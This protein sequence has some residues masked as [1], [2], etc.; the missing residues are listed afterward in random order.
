M[1]PAAPEIERVA[2]QL[3][4]YMLGAPYP[5]I[6]V[7]LGRRRQSVTRWCDARY[8]AA[9]ASCKMTPKARLRRKM[10]LSA[11]YDAAQSGEDLQAVYQRWGC[12]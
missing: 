7:L 4:R 5:R 2:A 3:M 10:R 12:A 1:R 6:A 8:A 9:Q 11:R